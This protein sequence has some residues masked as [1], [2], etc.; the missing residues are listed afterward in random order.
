MKK[1][2]LSLLIFYV[3]YY[4]NIHT[5][6][7]PLTQSQEKNVEY[8]IQEIK[9]PEFKNLVHPPKWSD[10]EPEYSLQYLQ[11]KKNRYPHDLYLLKLRIAAR[12]RQ[13][14]L[15]HTTQFIP[16]QKERKK[17]TPPASPDRVTHQ[18]S[19]HKKTSPKPAWR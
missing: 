6:E 14:E 18:F 19:P 11:R 2:Y 4:Q 9:S 10:C 3:F 17:Q 16:L 7:T 13:D 5:S 12:K 1:L 15:A 8:C